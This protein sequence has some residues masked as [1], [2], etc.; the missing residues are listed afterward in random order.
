MA[1]LTSPGSDCRASQILLSRRKHQCSPCSALEAF[2]TSQ[3]PA[4]SQFALHQQLAVPSTSACCLS[5]Q[6]HSGAHAQN[7]STPSEPWLGCLVHP[8]QS[9]LTR[10]TPTSQIKYTADLAIW[11]ALNIVRPDGSVQSIADKPFAFIEV[12][13]GSVV[14]SHEAHN[15]R[16]ALFVI[17]LNEGFA[18][19]Q[20]VFYLALNKGRNG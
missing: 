8:E 18:S 13:D 3:L 12:P 17:A 5:F 19:A 10:K 20:L 1:C 14:E 11:I 16:T 4:E 7:P 9:G 6:A 15:K 2:T